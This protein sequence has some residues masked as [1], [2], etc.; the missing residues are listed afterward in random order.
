MLSARAFPKCFPCAHYPL[1]GETST[2][3]ISGIPVG[4]EE[5]R[6]KSAKII[7]ETELWGK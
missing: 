7:S 1:G 2:W 6:K 5:G 4:G 3:V